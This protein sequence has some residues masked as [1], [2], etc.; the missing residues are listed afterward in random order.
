[1]D[2]KEVETLENT[3]GTVKIK[4]LQHFFGDT[5]LKARDQ[6]HQTNR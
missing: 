1:M 3:L 5:L 6:T 4:A 2:K